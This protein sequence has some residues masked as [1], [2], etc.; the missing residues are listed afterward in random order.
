M[1]RRCGGGA[2]DG[3]RARSGGRTSSRSLEFPYQTHGRVPV[4]QRQL[5][6]GARPSCSRCSTTRS[7]APTRRPRG[8]RAGYLGIGFSTYIEACSHRAVQGGGR[9]RRPGRPLGVAARCACTRP[10]K[11]T[12]FTGLALARAGARDDVRPAGGR[13]AA[14]S[15]WSDVE[16]VHGDTGPVPFGMGTYGSRSASVGGTAIYMSRR[17]DQGEGQED[18]RASARGDAE[19]TSSTQDGQFQVKGSPGKA[20]KPFGAGRAD[21]LRAAQLSGGARAGARGDVAS[22]TR[23]TSASPSGPTPAWS[24]SDPDTGQVKIL[25]YVAV[26]DVGNVINPMIVDG[27]VHGGIAQGV[28][29]GALR[30]RGLRRR[31]GPAR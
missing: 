4:R 20:V 11:V 23:R 2:Q 25:R 22:T 31:V 5:R 8:S 15:R 29:A 7:S 18:R 9:A 13:R 21:G 30:G 19:A 16:I 27:M 28:G 3:R 14:A 6:A 26:D 12:V 24:R 1:V 17:Q 10:A